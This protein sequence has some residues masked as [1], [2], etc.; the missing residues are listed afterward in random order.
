MTRMTKRFPRFA[1]HS[2]GSDGATHFKSRYVLHFLTALLQLMQTCWEVGAPGHGKGV[3]DLLGALVKQA[4]R[5]AER[6]CRAEDASR[7]I[8][9]SDETAMQFKALQLLEMLRWLA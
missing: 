1:L 6:R 2:V 3:W 5:M 9:V 7:A 8:G 4:L